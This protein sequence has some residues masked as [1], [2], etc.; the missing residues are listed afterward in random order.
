MG[1]T[2]NS[3]MQDMQVFCVWLFI[4]AAVVVWQILSYSLLAVPF[5]GAYSY[6]IYLTHTFAYINIHFFLTPV[7]IL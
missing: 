1:F 4:Y 6:L 5:L 7:G 3:F 2:T